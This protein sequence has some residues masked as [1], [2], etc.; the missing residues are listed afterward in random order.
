MP[1]ELKHDDFPARIMG[2]GVLMILIL[3]GGLER[4]RTFLAA[5]GREDAGAGG[6]VWLSPGRTLATFPP[7]A[8]VTRG[9]RPPP[10]APLACCPTRDPPCS[11]APRG[12]PDPK[13]EA[14]F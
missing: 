6:G 4:S 12:R 9:Q 11:R 2:G 10:R 7:L 1:R 5:C 3:R 8:R 13:Q 14:P